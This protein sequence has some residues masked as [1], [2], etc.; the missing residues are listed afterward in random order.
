MPASTHSLLGSLASLLG[1]ILTVYMWIVVVRTLI[2]WVSPNPYN[3]V[4][5]FLAKI[6][7]PVLSYIRRLLPVYH[8][9]IDFSP[10][11]L[12]LLIVFCND[13]VVFSLNW[14]AQDRGAAGVGLIFIISLIRM[15]QGLLFAYMVVVFVRA[16]L[17]WIS[18]DP[19]NILVRFV[20]GL[21]DPVLY[22][23][24][25]LVPLVFGGIDFTPWALVLVIYLANSALDRVMIMLLQAMA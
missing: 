12:I 18:P 24:R 1:F 2:S 5:Q 8:G 21:T 3:P 13:F 7:D 15:I 10:V 9:G 25:R 6:T 11:I 14:L 16:I 22:R 20:S 17:S 23:I 4:V 19:Y